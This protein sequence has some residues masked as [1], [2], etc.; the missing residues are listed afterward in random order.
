MVAMLCAFPLLPA[1]PVSLEVHDRFVC[2]LLFLPADMRD[3]DLP[4][5]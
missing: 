1:K 5:A 2:N 4:G 3:Y